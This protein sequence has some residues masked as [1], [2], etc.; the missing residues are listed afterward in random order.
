MSSGFFLLLLLLLM[1]LVVSGFVVHY[2]TVLFP[3]AF[4]ASLLVSLPSRINL[5]FN[6]PLCLS[7][8]LACSSV[9][10]GRWIFVEF[11]VFLLFFCDP[12]VFAPYI[13]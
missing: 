5:L 9:F 8:S 2:I 7:S 4:V 10:T 3:L 1:V 12:I 11:Y 6:S 13:C